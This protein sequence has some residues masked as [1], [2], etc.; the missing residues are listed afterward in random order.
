MARLRD[1]Y[2]L[3][4]GRGADVLAIGPDGAY[5]FQAYWNEQRIPFVGLPDPTHVVARRY[6]QKVNIFRLGRMPLVS[7]VDQN[8]IIRYF[9][10]GESMSDIPEN[11]ILLEVI[12]KLN[13]ASK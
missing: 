9:H 13:A 2:G 4:T 6:K 1:E 8:G 12:D 3:F 11:K 5:A 10:Q 7:I